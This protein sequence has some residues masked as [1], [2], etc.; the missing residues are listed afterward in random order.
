MNNP[1]L[2]WGA[3]GHGRVVLDI[4]LNIGQFDRVCFL[5]DDPEKRDKPF[6]G[7]VVLG[8]PEKLA[9]LRGYR[10]AI[11][12]GNN[13]TRAK[14]FDLASRAGL[15]PAVLVHRSATISASASIGE[16][17]VV[18]P[19]AVVNAAAR[20]GKNCIINSGAIVEHDC[21][22]GANVHI[23]PRAVLGGGVR[24]CTFAQIGMGAIVLPRVV[25]GQESTVG[26]GAVVLKEVP[27]QRTVIG[28][29]AK[30]RN[31]ERT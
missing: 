5:D 27:A 7:Q 28:V 16:G 9:E 1:L 21:D 26:A 14:C 25:V 3:G 4:A 8:G 10:F 2:I 12:V 30:M 20:I 31:H 23:S 17:T 13:R 19:G 24:V 18:M 11:A 22:V 15:I 6:C 29:P